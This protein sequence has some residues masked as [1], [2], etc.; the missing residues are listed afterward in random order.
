MDQIEGKTK[1]NE[2]AEALASLVKSMKCRACAEPEAAMVRYNGYFMGWFCNDHRPDKMKVKRAQEL[3]AAYH[4]SKIGILR[5]PVE[6][7]EKDH[8][9]HQLAVAA[10]RRGEAKY[11]QIVGTFQPR[12]KRLNR[13]ERRRSRRD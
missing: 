12:I 6:F 1:A 7:N 3:L 2:K 8:P 10:I 5:F 9:F 4:D 13:A 11:D